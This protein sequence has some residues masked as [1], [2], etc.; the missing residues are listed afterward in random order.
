MDDWS[1]ITREVVLIE[2]LTHLDLNEFQQLLIVDH[3]DLVECHSDL[4]HTDLTSEQ[5]MLAGLGHRAVSC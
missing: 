3:V 5:H 1:V 2:E 4:W